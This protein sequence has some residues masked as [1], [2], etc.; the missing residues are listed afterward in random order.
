MQEIIKYQEIDAKVRKLE[1]EL[2]SSAN[3]KSASEMQQYLKDGQARL[4]K[5][6]EVAANLTGQYEKATKLYNDFIQKLEA[7]SKNVDEAGDEA[8]IA[9]L[10]KTIENFMNTAENLENNL[11]VLA[12]KII[13][14][15]KEFEAL[16][17][18]AKKAKH[19]LEI[20]KINYAKEREQLE[21]K[22]NDLKSE[23]A[24]Q[25]SK[26]APALLNKYNSKS[27]SKLFP[28]FVAEINGS[29]GG[30]RMQIS[31]SRLSSLK[32]DGVIE[33]ENCGRFI[34]SKQ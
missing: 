21:P 5:L 26:V 22:I 4:L 32:A 12:N 27:E 17:N 3:R 31:A 29:C 18:K 8:K 25:K 1:N 19:N 11:N 2:A 7:L 33:C 34:Y 9:E 23:L 10:D 15:N 16:M 6:E 14:V 20:Y 30:C 24:K 28:I 13:A